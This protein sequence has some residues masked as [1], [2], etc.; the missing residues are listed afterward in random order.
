MN[1]YIFY[2]YMHAYRKFHGCPSALLNL[3]E[4]WIEELDEHNKIGVVAIDVSKAFDC[5]PREPILE[6]L[7]LY[8][9]GD[10][11]VNLMRSYLP[12]RS[13]THIRVGQVWKPG[14]HNVAS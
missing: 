12:G 10:K 9:L 3:T 14:Y 7:K 8:G 2:S 5:L 6:K 13:Q 11:A 1:L 4:R